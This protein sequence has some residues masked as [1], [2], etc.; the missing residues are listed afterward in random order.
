MVISENKNILLSDE[1]VS[2]APDN[3]HDFY[4]LTKDIQ[5]NC[6]SFCFSNSESNHPYD[7]FRTLL[8]P[9]F[10][11]AVRLV[12]ENRNL[13]LFGIED[14]VL[15]IDHK[16]QNYSFIVTSYL[17]E[18]EGVKRH[19]SIIRLSDRL[20]SFNSEVNKQ[21]VT[22]RNLNKLSYKCISS[23]SHDF[24]TP[25]SIIYANIQLL[26]Y[27]EDQ[28][29]DQTI[30]DAFTLSRMA[31]KSLLRV[32]DKVTVVDSINKGRLEYKPTTVKL[33]NLCESIVKNINEIEIVPDRVKYVHD[34]SVGEVAVDEYL[35]S[36]MFAHLIHNGL[37]FSKKDYKVLF[38]C[39]RISDEFLTFTVKDSGIGIAEEQLENI[40]AYFKRTD[41]EVTEGI[42]LGFAIVKECLSLQNGTFDIKS[43][44]GRGTS[45]TI[46]LPIDHK[47]SN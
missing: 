45:V 40:R 23:V 25:L 18:H 9:H 8:P 30:E 12:I 29:D 17:S 31:V 21:L 43:E 39:R 33:L 5:G 11:K 32:L 28:L 3:I 16:G 36:S 37:S 41:S 47:T 15:N 1:Q 6:I 7:G 35:F 34:E 2:A 19:N 26:E 22:Q 38:V 10:R 14:V 4:L 42:G 13:N 46:N 24:R 27:H 20:N 44:I